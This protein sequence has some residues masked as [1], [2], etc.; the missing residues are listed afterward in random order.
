MTRNGQPAPGADIN[1]VSKVRK[2]AMANSPATT[3]SST[4]RKGEERCSQ[5][6]PL[7][8]S[9]KV[10]EYEIRKILTAV[11]IL[12]IARKS[13]ILMGELYLGERRKAMKALLKEIGICFKQA[14]IGLWRAFAQLGQRY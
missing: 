5:R 4:S 8:T 9:I 10:Q 7:P 3:A 2:S 12:R 1:S 6:R 11:S 14:G 13:W